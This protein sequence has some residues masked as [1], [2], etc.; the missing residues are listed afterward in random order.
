M[1]DTKQSR[2]IINDKE[3]NQES[4][5]IQEGVTTKKISDEEITALSM[6][7]PRRTI[8]AKKSSPGIL[9]KKKTCPYCNKKLSHWSLYRHINDM[10][11]AKPS[12]VPCKLCKKMFR[13]MN[14][15]NSH[16]SRC[17]SGAKA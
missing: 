16:K 4:E 9:T 8:P 3:D 5:V 12:F 2:N 11:K 6:R 7:S 14:S 17:H 13:T 15:L 10:H 1:E